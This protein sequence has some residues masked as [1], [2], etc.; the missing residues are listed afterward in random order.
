MRCLKLSRNYLTFFC[1]LLQ[2]SVTL[3][4][5]IQYR[6]YMNAYLRL[7]RLRQQTILDLCFNVGC[8][9]Y[10]YFDCC[11]GMRNSRQVRRLHDFFRKHIISSHVLH[12]ISQTRNIV[13]TFPNYSLSNQQSA[14]F[15]TCFCPFTNSDMFL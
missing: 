14:K 10:C 4:S 12:P 15:L 1:S 3:K 5:L 7:S 8:E 9:Q 6:T 13:H 11:M 2:V